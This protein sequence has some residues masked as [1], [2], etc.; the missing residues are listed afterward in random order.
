M[1]DDAPTALR[2][3]CCPRLHDLAMELRVWGGESLPHRL[4]CD[5]PS[6]QTFPSLWYAL[7]L[8]SYFSSLFSLVAL[9]DILVYLSL[10]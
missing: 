4:P 3:L 1:F 6:F 7:P 9:G 10:F 5:G 8:E 2:G